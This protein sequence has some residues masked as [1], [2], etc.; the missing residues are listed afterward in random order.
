M[1]GKGVSIL[2]GCLGMAALLLV[3]R[4]D[5]QTSPSKHEEHKIIQSD[6]TVYRPGPAALPPGAQ[7]AVLEGDPDKEGNVT[8]RIKVPAN[9][10]IPPHTHPKLER[11]T[12]LEGTLKIGMG[13]VYEETAMTELGSGGFFVMPPGMEHFAGSETGGV[14]QLNVVGPWRIDYLNPEDDPRRKP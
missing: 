12:V 6:S 11:V 9:Y 3:G 13:R 5:G 7:F 1:N 8:M 10:R 4:M 14:I 2:V